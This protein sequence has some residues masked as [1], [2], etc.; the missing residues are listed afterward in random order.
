MVVGK[1]ALPKRLRQ[2][3]EN[4][5]PPPLFSPPPPLPPSLRQGEQTPGS[6]APQLS[7]RALIASGSWTRLAPVCA[8]E[9]QK[10]SA[11][12]SFSPFS[13]SS[14][15]GNKLRIPVLFFFSLSSPRATS[16]RSL[17][18][19]GM[20]EPSLGT[21]ST[22][23]SPPLSAARQERALPKRTAYWPAR[24]LTSLKSLAPA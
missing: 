10:A 14:Q 4:D 18:S 20:S 19:A 6:G 21:A 24:L 23:A 7:K 2:R 5:I 1:G 8:R 3:E 11:S 13:P 17:P 22:S 15:S 9:R 12:L 16:P